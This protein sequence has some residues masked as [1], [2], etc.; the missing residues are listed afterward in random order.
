MMTGGHGFLADDPAGV[1]TA[2]ITTR[3]VP[4][5]PA[6]HRHVAQSDVTPQDF[7]DALSA[8]VAAGTSA[9]GSVAHAWRRSS[10]VID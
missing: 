2:M 7:A 9:R 6:H 1:G 3:A 5:L 10:H 8:G 4:A